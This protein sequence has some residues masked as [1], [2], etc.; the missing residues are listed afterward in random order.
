M[1]VSCS[2]ID[3]FMQTIQPQIDFIKIDV[4]GSEYDVLTGAIK[5]IEKFK[6]VILYEYS[7]TIRKM[8]E[9]EYTKQSFEL[10]QKLEYTQ[11]Q[12]VGES[13]LKKLDEYNSDINCNIIAFHK[14][15]NYSKKIR[16]QMMWC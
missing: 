13:H 6:P 14:S 15:T 5:T 3:I 2:T 12:I 16:S 9:S 4:E 8:S 10:L 1:L 11:F 7:N